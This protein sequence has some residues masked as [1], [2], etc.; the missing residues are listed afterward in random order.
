MTLFFIEVVED[1]GAVYT[2][3]LH[4]LVHL[5]LAVARRLPLY[6]ILVM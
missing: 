6:K 3:Q 4:T 1:T 5:S 2:I